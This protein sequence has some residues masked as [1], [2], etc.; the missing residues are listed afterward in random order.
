MLH[1]HF[2][3]LDSD[4]WELPASRDS[5]P[6]EKRRDDFH[7]SRVGRA[8]FRLSTGQFTPSIVLFIYLFIHSLRAPF[9]FS[10]SFITNAV[11]VCVEKRY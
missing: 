9:L 7:L 8:R 11:R 10:L 4:A 5:L 3:L 1:S 6:G 2:Y